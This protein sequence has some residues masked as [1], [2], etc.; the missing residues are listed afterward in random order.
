M[1]LFFSIEKAKIKELHPPH[2]TKTYARKTAEATSHNFG[3]A[4]LKRTPSQRHI[5]RNS[6]DTQS[7]FFLFFAHATHPESGILHKENFD[8][9]FVL[10]PSFQSSKGKAC[11]SKELR[12]CFIGAIFQCPKPLW[13]LIFYKAIIPTLQSQRFIITL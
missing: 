11:G 10:C 7:H 12:N 13:I 3:L 2:K 5:M 9:W 1:S 8:F 6:P 4:S